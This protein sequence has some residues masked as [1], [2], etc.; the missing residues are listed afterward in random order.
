MA[1]SAHPLSMGS[2]ISSSLAVQRAC[3]PCEAFQS[4]YSSSAHCFLA[5]EVRELCV[6]MAELQD[7]ISL[8]LLPTWVR[9]KSLCIKPLRCQGA[10]V[11]TVSIVTNSSG[12]PGRSVL[13]QPLWR[14]VTPVVYKFHLESLLWRSLILT[15]VSCGAGSH[16]PSPQVSCWLHDKLER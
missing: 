1:D 12:S 6:E 9:N 7:W 14:S 13:T 4:Q 8:R 10:V 2:Y 5:L 15:H 16:A 11:N 3:L